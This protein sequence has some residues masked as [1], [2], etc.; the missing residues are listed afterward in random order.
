VRFVPCFAGITNIPVS[1][2]EIP[3][4]HLPAKEYRAFGKFNATS[5]IH[6]YD[7]DRLF[8]V[9]AQKGNTVIF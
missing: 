3:K 2:I 5:A 6:Q 1:R 8:V 7:R 4:T 9:F